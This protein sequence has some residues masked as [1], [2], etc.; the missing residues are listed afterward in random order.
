MRK[1]IQEFESPDKVI[2]FTLEEEGGRFY[3][4]QDNQEPKKLRGTKSDAFDK[5]DGLKMFVASNYTKRK[6]R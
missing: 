4:C 6:P 1:V 3:I 2:R 5:W